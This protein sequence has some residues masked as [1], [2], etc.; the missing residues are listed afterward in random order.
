[1]GQTGGEPTVVDRAI[2][3]RPRADNGRSRDPDLTTGLDQ[4]GHPSVANNPTTLTICCFWARTR[5][6]RASNLVRWPANRL[7]N[8]RGA[9]R[10][11]KSRPLQRSDLH[12][13]NFQYA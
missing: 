11:P 3:G 10:V 8:H 12:F 6:G 13:N 1:M 4:T 9:V 5:P 7:A 2:D